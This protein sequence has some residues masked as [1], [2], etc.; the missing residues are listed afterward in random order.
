MNRTVSI[1]F[2]PSSASHR[3]DDVMQKW[4]LHKSQNKTGQ[5][6]KGCPVCCIR[7]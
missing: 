2:T 7:A 3:L 4:L 5:L 6:K 1:G